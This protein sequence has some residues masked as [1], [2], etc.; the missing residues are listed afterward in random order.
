MSR[1]GWFDGEGFDFRKGVVSDPNGILAHY[2]EDHVYS[3][4][5]WREQR[6]RLFRQMKEMEPKLSDYAHEEVTRLLQEFE[7]LL[8]MTQRVEGVLQWSDDIGQLN[9][10]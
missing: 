2:G 4:A 10:F 7:V 9:L 8:F 3:Q 5:E 6:E 1:D